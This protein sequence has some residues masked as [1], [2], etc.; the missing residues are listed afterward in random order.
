[1][2][3]ERAREYN[4]GLGRCTFFF[5]SVCVYVCGVELL[6]STLLSFYALTHQSSI[7]ITICRFYKTRFPCVLASSS[8]VYSVCPF[9]DFPSLVYFLSFSLVKVMPGLWLGI[10][11][12]YALLL[13]RAHHYFSVGGL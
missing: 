3:E 11:V 5:F 7:T 10:W 9:S 12:Q 1:M 13:Y 4:G 6:R 8:L 2:E